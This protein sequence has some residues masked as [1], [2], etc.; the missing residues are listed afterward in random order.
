MKTFLRGGE[1]SYKPPTPY[2]SGLEE[3]ITEQLSKR[4]IKFHYEEYEIAYV[5]PASNHKYT[6]DV[7]LDNG[8]I[9]EIKGLWEA[10]DRKK[11]LLLRK[12]YPD[13][14]IRFVFQA[15]NNKIYKGSKTTYAKYCDKYGI[16]W[17]KKDI[18]VEW[19]KEPKRNIPACL[20]LKKGKK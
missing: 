9:V 13:L 15:P 1:Y 20:K 17:A 11:H 16:K 18:P 8:V 6:P 2:R 10:D 12:Q 19:I 7:I 4:G 5:I 14:D 3:R